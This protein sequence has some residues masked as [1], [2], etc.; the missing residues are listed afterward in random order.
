M[1]VGRRS[2]GHSIQTL[3]QCACILTWRTTEA[4]TLGPCPPGNQLIVESS[5]LRC[6]PCS[7]G[8][9][10][11][12]VDA[13]SCSP[14]RECNSWNHTSVPF[15]FEAQYEYQ[16]N[17][18][19]P[20]SDTQCQPYSEQCSDNEY[21][22]TEP[23]PTSDFVCTSCSP[24]FDEHYAST[25][26]SLY[27]DRE[28][29]A[30]D[31]C[32][33]KPMDLVFVLD[34]SFSVVVSSGQVLALEFAS[35]VT[36][37]FPPDIDLRVSLIAYSSAP[38][39]VQFTFLDT[40]GLSRAALRQRILNVTPP[41]GG[42]SDLASALQ[43]VGEDVV[44]P[45]NANNTGF[46]SF[47][48]PT[49]MIL[50]ANGISSAPARTREES[51]ALQSQFPELL[52][53]VGGV[54]DAYRTEPGARAE[55]EYI[56]GF[57]PARVDHNI[58][59][60]NS[61]RNFITLLQGGFCTP[62]C[63]ADTYEEASCTPTTNRQ[64][65]P[66]TACDP[67]SEYEAF[68]GLLVGEDSEEDCIGGVTG[69]N[70]TRVSDR[71]CLPL[72]NCTASEYIHRQPTPTSDRGCV[73]LV[74]SCGAGTFEVGL[75]TPTSDRLCTPCPTGQYLAGTQASDCVSVRTCR[76]GEY[77][78]RAP[79]TTTD[80]RCL[81]CGHNAFAPWPSH[82]NQSCLLWR[83]CEIH[84]YAPQA[85]TPTT[86]RMCAL[87]GGVDGPRCPEGSWEY[88]SCTATT[89]RVCTRC[90]GC[91]LEEEDGAIT[92]ARVAICNHTLDT[93]SATAVA[94]AAQTGDATEIVVEEDDPMELVFVIVFA[95]L[96][97]ILLL[98]LAMMILSR[99][100][101]KRPTYTEEQDFWWSLE[102]D[103]EVDCADKAALKARVL[104]REAL[105]AQ[106][107]TDNDAVC[108]PLVEALV[109]RA[110]AVAAAKEQEKEEFDLAV[111][112]RRAR[113]QEQRDATAIE[114]LQKQDV[115]TQRL[116]DVEKDAVQ[117]QKTALQDEIA[118]LEK[119]LQAQQAG[120]HDEAARLAAEKQ[121]VEREK[122]EAIE[123]A[124]QV[125]EQRRLDEARAREAERAARE[126]AEQ[127]RLE[128]ERL[129]A[130]AAERAQQRE[131]QRQKEAAAARLAEVELERKRQ[132]A[133]ERAR[134]AE[135]QLQRE[136]ERALRELE[137]EQARER[138]E[139]E[140]KKREEEEAAK[141]RWRL[142]RRVMVEEQDAAGRLS[143]QQMANFG[144]GR[145]KEKG[146]PKPQVVRQH[147]IDEVVQD[148]RDGIVVDGCNSRPSP[149]ELT[150]SSSTDVIVTRT[151]QTF[152][153]ERDRERREAAEAAKRQADEAAEQRRL[154][155]LEEM[156]MRSTRFGT[157]RIAQVDEYEGETS[158]TM[159]QEDLEH[160]L[161]TS[162]AKDSVMSNF[163]AIVLSHVTAA[164]TPSK[165][166]QLVS[167]ARDA[168]V[169]NL[170]DVRM[171]RADVEEL[172][173]IHADKQKYDACQFGS[174]V[175][176]VFQVTASRHLVEGN[177]TTI[178]AS[179]MMTAMCDLFTWSGKRN[180]YVD[181]MP[182]KMW[183]DK[184]EAQS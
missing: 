50:L 121:R 22:L 180:V 80:T 156:N 163:Y 178:T 23:T 60:Y 30:C 175:D 43:L 105:A 168:T 154:Q 81:A 116:L 130:E 133:L 181:V 150:S 94:A 82:T 35:N 166:V 56:A 65:T 131:L 37:L 126:A 3:I 32:T 1:K 8:T 176:R 139:E 16:S 64:C 108:R 33:L 92:I 109:E 119:Q 164:T 21:I 146:R 183:A 61:L 7:L 123:R 40:I 46:R 38:A 29:V 172:L 171:T 78:S 76:A 99:L 39:R 142:Q 136:R 97:C 6:V 159:G 69:G 15:T 118:A 124:R 104:E 95:L 144:G 138:E 122:A 135:E 42:S 51:D 49:A 179:E 5:A 36:S 127:A 66:L 149:A 63:P 91:G 93:C 59:D 11:T 143:M 165:Y 106:R 128:Q 152:K 173:G 151:T 70:C 100:R 67:L 86:D 145:I 134:L 153:S 25:E 57:N 19:T 101:R 160:N 107:V 141:Q 24:C 17:P 83:T 157:V 14:C 34:M 9:F 96:C 72:T 84:H 158:V 103:V 75:P 52:S 73:R 155:Q 55:L 20:T 89:D 10:N 2:L 58:A 177:R 18:C 182:I 12:R 115:K 112:R 44:N 132:A 13:S 148:D 111:F 74:A 147:V 87:C 170:S 162:A 41:V 102:E 77:M 68:P 125:E 169:V 85:G 113:Q 129:E 137:E 48:V 45:F 54:G 28:C 88:R 31:T 110:I 62:G 174:V 184:E 71:L 98:L 140:R 47:A 117:R 26:C 4:Q 161:R 79:T 27:T 120:Y 114:K 90:L 167:N 53:F